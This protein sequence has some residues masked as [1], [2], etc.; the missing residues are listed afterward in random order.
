MDIAKC[1]VQETCSS[2][3]HQIKNIV[4]RPSQK[5]IFNTVWTDDEVKRYFIK[6]NGAI[7]SIKANMQ[8]LDFY[9]PLKEYI[10]SR[11]NDARPEDSPS[12]IVYRIVNNIE[13]KPK[14]PLCGKNVQFKTYKLGYS[15]YCSHKCAL[16]D[17]GKREM[18]KQ[19]K[20]SCLEKYGVDNCAKLES[21]KEKAKQTSLKKY[22]VTHH[23]KAIGYKEQYAASNG[24]A[25]PMLLPGVKEKVRKTNIKKYGGPTP[26]CSPEVKAKMDF[27][28]IV[29]K[30]S[31]TK[32][33][34]HTFNTSSEEERLFSILAKLFG[35]DD[36]IR[37]YSSKAYPYRCDFYLKDKDVY[38]ELN[39][40]QF[41]NCQPYRNY[42]WQK[43]VVSLMS[44]RS[45]EMKEKGGKM[46]VTQYDNI[47]STWA[48][49]DVKKR[50][51]AK[52]NK[53]KYLE[54][55]YVPDDKTLFQ[56]V[57][58]VCW[59]NCQFSLYDEKVLNCSKQQLVDDC[60]NVS[61]PGNEK[62]LSD[63]PI[64]DSYLP[65]KPSPKEAWMNRFYLDTAVSNLF[66]MLNYSIE[67]GK[68]QDFLVKH[69]NALEDWCENRR[70]SKQIFKYVLDR[71][72]IAKI[73]PKVTA[74][75]KSDM[76]KIIRES[77]YDLSSGVYCPMAGFGGIVEAS[78]QWFIN[79]NL[80][81]EGK[82][83]AYDINERFVNYYKFDGVRDMLAQK[84]ET[85]KTVI[86]CPPFGTSYE[87]WKGTPDE[88]SDISFL[89][90]YELIHEYIKA[91]QYIIIGPELKTETNSRTGLFGKR[92]GIQLWDDELF[93]EMKS[94]TKE[95]RALYN[96]KF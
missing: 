78:K 5:K 16:S 3:I 52:K 48:E 9:Y 89:D 18:A 60:L 35:N 62:W 13:E 14:C 90:W 61:F 92:E 69:K 53:L 59:N 32:Q 63:N 8:C 44:Q 74:L 91:P 24:V 30:I 82:I 38:I 34:N 57:D 88:M 64:W 40:S 76:L 49:R 67:T 66:Y 71:F 50:D 75:S 28:S 73:A 79:N 37:Q 43:R 17:E 81:W 54:L 21:S 19:Y 86:V 10:Y 39:A 55:F 22:G 93:Q 1:G 11:F 26:F 45:A 94:K 77:G 80:S 36:V 51:T 85:E 72:T 68:Y 58:Y 25:S 65:G 7:N 23:S 15:L 6:E 27:Q 41:H 42:A 33:K 2:D 84:I 83:E 20:K 46:N 12:E 96:L 4:M 56:C 31:E 95:E 29:Q 47:I 70:K 87:H